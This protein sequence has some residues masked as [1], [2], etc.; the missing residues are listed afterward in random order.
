MR[1]F[2][3]RFVESILDLAC[4][5]QAIPAPTFHETKRAGFFLKEFTGLGLAEVQLDGVGNVL[6]RLPGS[7]GGRPLV[8]S[9]HIDTVY[10]L[11]T[12]LSVHRL[13]DRLAGPG[14]GDNALG[15]A[16]LVGLARSLKMRSVTLPGDL[17]LAANVGEEGLGD[18]RGMQALVDRFQGEPLA[19]LVIEG[20]GLGTILNRGLGVER[21]R[22][23]TAFQHSPR[24]GTPGSITASLPRSTSCAPSSPG[25]RLSSFHA[26]RAPR[27]TPE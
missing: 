4:V 25:W 11:E 17:W 26:A 27:S 23:A 15:A 6:G 10:P 2:P 22:S 8:V 7:A 24:A 18:L 19:Y 13:D 16:A 1:S 14:I 21:Y 5:I 12:P 20:M 9:A 3:P